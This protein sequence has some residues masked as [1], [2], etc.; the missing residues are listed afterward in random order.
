[1][2]NMFHI[3]ICGILTSRLQN[4][5][6]QD[7]KNF[8]KENIGYPGRKEMDTPEKWDEALDK[9]ILAFEYVISWDDW[10]LDDPKYNYIRAESKYDDEYVAKIR[11]SYLAEDKRRQF[12]IRE[13]LELFAKWFRD[14]WI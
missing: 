7:L 3:V 1:M 4:L 6:F 14:L 9:M 12:A 5:F 2:A 10:W 8:K 11:N 13:G